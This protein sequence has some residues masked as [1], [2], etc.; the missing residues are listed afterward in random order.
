M[1]DETFILD[2]L[3][4]PIER[5][6]AD[7]ES[8]SHPSGMLREECFAKGLG[9]CAEPVEAVMSFIEIKLPPSTGGKCVILKA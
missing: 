8:S 1:P 6:H 4:I 3:P 5:V 7:R 9:R 2:D